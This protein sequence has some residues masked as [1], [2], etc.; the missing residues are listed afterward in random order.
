MNDDFIIAHLLEDQ[1]WIRASDETAQ[2]PAAG[3]QVG[4]VKRE[5][6]EPL[7]TGL[8]FVCAVGRLRLDISEHLSKIGY[9]VRGVTEFQS[10]YFAQTARTSSSVA[11]SR[12]SA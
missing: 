11:N 2:A 6:D 8:H 5:G 3:A 9:S 10:P 7:N 12:W 1:V 4:V